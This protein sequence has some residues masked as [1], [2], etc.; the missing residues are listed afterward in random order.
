LTRFW[1]SKIW[2][3]DAL[4]GLKADEL[5]REYKLVMAD[6]IVYASAL[7]SSANLLTC[8]A[9]LEGLPNVHWIKKI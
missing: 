9:R 6:A 7:L 4:T 5:H 3:L 1:L 2:T 8:D